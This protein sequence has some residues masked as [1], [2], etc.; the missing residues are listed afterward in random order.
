VVETSRNYAAYSYWLESCED[1]LTPRPP[2]DGSTDVDVAILGAGYSG[3]WTAYY[4]LKSDPSLR[5]AIAE[6]HIAGFGASG[7]NGGWCSSGFPIGLAELAR[8]YG[9]EAT[10]N[11]QRAM[12]AS[13]DEVGLVAED[14]GID[15]D[16]EK[17]GALRFARGQHQLPAIDSAME[18]YRKFGL[19]HHYQ[20]L[21]EDE[22]RQRVNVAGALGAVFTP[23]CATIHPGKLARGL[24]RTVERLGATIYE[25]TEVTSFTQGA[26]PALH[27]VSGDIRAKVIVLAGESYLSQLDQ[28][29]RQVI[30]IY[31]LIVLTRPLSDEQW[32]EIGWRGRECVSSNRLTVDYLSRT[33]DGRIL[34]GGRGAPYHYGSKISDGFDRHDGTH[35]MLREAAMEWFPSLEPD[36]FS[37][38]WG[39][40]LGVPRD[41]MP[42]MAFNRETGV[43][44]ARGYTGQ[45]VSTTNLAGRVLADLI[46]GANT[47]ITRL[48]QV[49]HQSP[50]WEPEPLRYLGVRYVQRTY[51]KLDDK[52]LRTGRPPD[53]STLGE[54]LS[55]H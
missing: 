23:H 28:L 8:R 7:R 27:T 38:A 34:F 37:H 55:K 29:A 41:W 5:I 11:L 51:A 25:Q 4:L 36:D 1:D 12:I 3:L 15:A 32:E 31:S 19:E 18:T 6:K 42:T 40:P 35:R 10:V 24:A 45:G 46:L 16:Y 47:D 53:G 52:A 26:S 54:R 9:D 14:E 48:P 49:G 20:R 44:T 22:A 50:D 30:P 13:V 21:T 39:G 17:G 33:T 43:A 2:L